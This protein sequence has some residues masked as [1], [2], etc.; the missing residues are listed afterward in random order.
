[1]SRKR[2]LVSAFIGAIVAASIGFSVVYTPQEALNLLATGGQRTTG[3]S[4]QE[5]LNELVAQQ[6]NVI[7]Q[8]SEVTEIIP[9]IAF[10]WDDNAS[11]LWAP[12]DSLLKNPTGA[13]KMRIRDIMHQFNI[14]GGIAFE[15]ESVLSSDTTLTPGTIS[16]PEIMALVGRGWDVG[17]VGWDESNS[18]YNGNY[19]LLAQG[20]TQAQVDTFYNN[21]NRAVLCQRDTLG[22]G[23]PRWISHSNSSA[24]WITDQ[25]A[26]RA[27]IEFGFAPGQTA[28]TSEPRPNELY[29]LDC[30]KWGMWDTGGAFGRPVSAIMQQR[31]NRYEI[32]QSFGENN[33]SSHVY[34]T[35]RHA[36]QTRG[37]VVFIG[38]KP[39]NWETT[40]QGQNGFYKLMEYLDTLRDAGRIQILTPGDAAHYYFNRPLSPLAN[41]I[42]T[43]FEDLDKD[44]HLD[45][46]FQGNGTNTAAADT[47]GIKP[48]GTATSGHNGKKAYSLNWAGEGNGTGMWAGQIA[49]APH[50]SAKACIAVIPP[51]GGGW[52]VQFECWVIADSAGA[53][54]TAITGDTVGVTFGGPFERYVNRFGTGAPTLGWLTDSGGAYFPL[55]SHGFANAAPGNVIHLVGRNNAS[56]AGT[57]KEWAHLVATWEV[58]EF[59]DYLFI[60]LWKT[61]QS[62]ANGIVISDY[63]VTFYQR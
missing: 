24:T 19:S 37:L 43:N 10:V 12:G 18:M 63:S 60:S 32:L 17:T 51:A 26:A 34:K 48:W 39:S 9:T 22:I 28:T 55:I 62:P 4:P 54:Y 46:W 2:T 35:I 45:W 57:A 5:A 42:P 56:R 49:D 31:L 40:L 15:P 53:T 36:M 38:H 41:V 13:V 44:G 20:Y 27:G 58:P 59:S 14:D 3:M 7:A 25:A 1:M 8:A 11:E 16:L 29:P 21:I 23:A 47:A 52:T 61:A 50:E 6:R 30:A 33:D